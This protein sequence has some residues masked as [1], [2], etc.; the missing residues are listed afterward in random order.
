M[1]TLV[2]ERAPL[3]A[4]IPSASQMQDHPVP[5]AFR[6]GRLY[7]MAPLAAVRFGP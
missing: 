5:G 4:S 3:I 1:T 7:V 6:V 2:A